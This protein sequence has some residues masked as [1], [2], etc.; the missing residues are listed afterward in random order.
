MMLN[1]NEAVWQCEYFYHVFRNDDNLYSVA[2][3]MAAN[4]LLQTD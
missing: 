2:R 4:S 3:I 1:R